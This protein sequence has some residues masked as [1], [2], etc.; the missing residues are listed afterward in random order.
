MKY[1]GQFKCVE[2]VVGAFSTMNE[3]YEPVNDVVLKNDEVLLAAYGAEN[4]E[5]Y[6]VVIFERNGK[7]YEAHGSHCSCQGLEGQWNPEET[8][9][10]AL[11][12]RFENM[13]EYSRNRMVEEY[14]EEFYSAYRRLVMFEL[15][16][17]NVLL[18]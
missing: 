7:L 6:A 11:M 15:F 10:E 16:E 13:D 9:L 3:S 17:R 4:Y 14:G 5:G 8:S 12:F 1:F 2:D 18:S